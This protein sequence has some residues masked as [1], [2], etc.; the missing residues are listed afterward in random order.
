MLKV[1][2]P[3]LCTL[4]CLTVVCEAQAQ[5]VCQMDFENNATDW[6]LNN[7]TLLKDPTGGTYGH[8]ESSEIGKVLSIKS[9]VCKIQGKKFLQVK[10]RYRSSVLS[11][12][13]HIGSWVLISFMDKH[14]KGVGMEGAV[15]KLSGD[16]NW[17]NQRFVIPKNATQIS[18][19]LR[20]QNAI[21]FVDW[22]DV[23]LRFVN[24]IEDKIATESVKIV[25]EAIDERSLQELTCF[26]LKRNSRGQWILDDGKIQLHNITEV[27]S[28]EK[29]PL[30]GFYFPEKYLGDSKLLYDIKMR[31]VPN[32]NSNG[33]G[34]YCMFQIGHNVLGAETNSVSTWV[35]SGNKLLSRLTSTQASGRN[36]NMMM[37][38]LEIRPGQICTMRTRFSASMLQ[39]FWDGDLINTMKMLGTMYWPK[40]KPIYFGGESPDVGLLNAKIESLTIRVFK[41]KIQA[42]LYGDEQWGYFIGNKSHQT[43]LEFL[44]DDARFCTTNFTITDKDKKV[45]VDKQDATVTSGKSHRIEIPKLKSGWYNLNVQIKK[46]DAV[47]NISRPFVCL[48][49]LPESD[50]AINSPFGAM[51]QMNLDP[52][53]Y[54]PQHME[55]VFAVC[56]KAGI[57]WWRLWMEWNAV[58]KKKGEYDWSSIDSVVELAEKYGIELYICFLG[59]TE[60]W[61]NIRSTLTNPIPYGMMT[62][63]HCMPLSLEDWATYITA[64]AQ[65]YKGKIKYYQVWNE[66]DARNAF[67]PFDTGKYVELLKVSSKALRDVDPSVKIGVGGFCAA[68]ARLNK[69]THT[70][71]DSAWGLPEF[72]SF[73]PQAYYDILDFHFYSMSSNMQRWEPMVPKVEKLHQYLATQSESEK[74]I[75][76]SETSFIASAEGTI[77]FQWASADP[78]TLQQQAARLVQWHTLSLANNIE[79]NFWYMVQ[80]DNGF[81]NSDFSPKPAFAAHAILADKLAGMELYNTINLSDNLRICQFSNKSNTKYIG[82][83][84]AVS[85]QELI[86]C[87]SEKAGEYIQIFDIY[88]N[89]IQSGNDTEAL[90]LA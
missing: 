44:G 58:Q 81:I 70:I 90:V 12:K 62:H 84:W 14:G 5:I 71:R 16:W 31:F 48:S 35:W 86:S 72:Y 28:D 24:Q 60:P 21:G 33:G 13:M 51:Q 29:F 11:S 22:D 50:S 61:Q 54:D 20:L 17:V 88:G 63:T 68:Y 40:Q 23:E 57:R 3:C 74:P 30:L 25:K 75:W 39:A 66:P 82:V 47:L 4:W 65:H 1:L 87:S 46:D 2:L 42:V 10:L 85:G 80:G 26:E 32:W 77:A 73:K 8:L 7:A 36:V 53:Q 64:F 89:E 69:F 45:L 56:K 15:C 37:N 67:Y 38:D 78:I 52:G 18:L 55:M 41:P 27:D 79:R 59:G 49:N 6:K 43:T 9:P 34:R 76:N 19:Q 83:L